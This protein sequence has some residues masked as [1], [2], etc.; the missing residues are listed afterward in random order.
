MQT[1]TTQRMSFEQTHMSGRLAILRFYAAASRLSAPILQPQMPTPQQ[2]LPHQLDHQG[3]GS[4]LWNQ[5][6]YSELGQ[7]LQLYPQH[8]EIL[9]KYSPLMAELAIRCLRGYNV[10]A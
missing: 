6:Y 4:N 10:S 1:A 5:I 8:A 3:G 2:L 9:T 7:M